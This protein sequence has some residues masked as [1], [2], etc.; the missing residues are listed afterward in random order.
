MM[1]LHSMNYTFDYDTNYMHFYYGHKLGFRPLKNTVNIV[2][3]GLPN[4]IKK[5][6]PRNYFYHHRTDAH[7]YEALLHLN[8]E[9]DKEKLYVFDFYNHRGPLVIFDLED[10]IFEPLDEYTYMRTDRFKDS[11]LNVDTTP[12]ID[13][14]YQELKV[15]LSQNRLRYQEAKKEL[16]QINILIH[17]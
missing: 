6:Y 17:L 7:P 8:S 14:N 9:S 16:K 11:F 4:D 5:R 1:L 3:K 10:D 15:Q 2:H 12:E 13:N